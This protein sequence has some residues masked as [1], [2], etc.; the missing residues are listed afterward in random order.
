MTPEERCQRIKLAIDWEFK[1]VDDEFIA[2]EIRAAVEEAFE[3][4]GYAF[5][6]AIQKC[7]KEKQE[8][9]AEAYEDAAKI[10]EI[11][12]GKCNCPA[13]IRARAKELK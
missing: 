9:K 7:L 1:A 12:R 5:Q 4:R 2:S 6:E 3:Q 11:N 13:Q 10:A 8:A